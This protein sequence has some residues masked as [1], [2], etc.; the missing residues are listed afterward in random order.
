MTHTYNKKEGE[1]GSNRLT[2]K[3]G[4][5]GS[6]ASTV[7]SLSQHT[8]QDKRLCGALHPNGLPKGCQV[9]SACK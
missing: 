5:I 4:Q 6:Y 7:S 2:H 1:K 3:Q 8:E 9:S